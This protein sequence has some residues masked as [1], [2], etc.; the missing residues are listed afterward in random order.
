M[1]ICLIL[2][3]TKELQRKSKANA[4]SEW[5]FQKECHLLGV[6]G[7]ALKNLLF[8]TLDNL[9][10]NAKASLTNNL[11][12]CLHFNSTWLGVITLRWLKLFP[13]VY[14]VLLFACIFHHFISTLLSMEHSGPPKL[15]DFSFKAVLLK[16][17]QRRY[18]A[19]GFT[20][21]GRIAAATL[22]AN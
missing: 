18:Y 11:T 6:I 7:W 13:A 20:L 9:C 15:Q 22:L 12:E 5:I 16:L 4:K 14:R 1:I 17:L 21:K 8:F 19:K 10:P 3:L 2:K